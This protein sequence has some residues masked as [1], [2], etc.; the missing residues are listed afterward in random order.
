MQCNGELI[1]IDYYCYLF[2]FGEIVSMIIYESYVFDNLKLSFSMGRY[3]I[4]IMHLVKK[5]TCLFHNS[6]FCIHVYQII[7]NHNNKNPLLK[8]IWCM[9]KPN[10]KFPNFV[11]AARTMGKLNWFGWTTTIVY[12]IWWNGVNV[13]KEIYIFGSSCR[14]TSPII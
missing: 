4:C 10:Y 1:Y 14:S 9:Y 12:C 3:L 8:S 11:H 6:I 7:Y 13:Y 2:V 5:F